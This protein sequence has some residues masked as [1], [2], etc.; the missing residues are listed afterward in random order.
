[1]MPPSEKLTTLKFVK[2]VCLF[3]AALIITAGCSSSSDETV[4]KQDLKNLVSLESPKDHPSQSS[5]IYI[6]SLKKV[7]YNQQTVLL[8]H[9]TF[10]DACTHLEE[11]THQVKRDSLYLD[12]KAWR[13]PKQM[14][15]Q[16]LTPF[17][18]IYDDLSSEDL[19]SHPQVII[20]G[21]SF[22]I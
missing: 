11:V 3:F 4:E 5:K 8:I 18:F 9:G 21:T 19:S 10:P 1:M 15:A 16:V 20:N 14:C 7:T 12:L 22:N 17:S 6:D 2:S 13:N